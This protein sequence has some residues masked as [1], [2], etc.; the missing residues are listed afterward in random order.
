MYANGCGVEKDDAEALRW[1]RKVATKAE[2][3]RSA[4]LA[5]IEG[6][7]SLSSETVTQRALEV[8]ASDATAAQTPKFVVDPARPFAHPYYWAPFVLMGNWL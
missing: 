3:L 8:A 2:A 5:L 6:D 4:Q 7:S 1:Y